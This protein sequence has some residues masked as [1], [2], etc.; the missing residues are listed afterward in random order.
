LFCLFLF[1]F[2]VVSDSCFEI[3]VKNQISLL[4]HI[5]H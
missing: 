3:K 4:L 5:S 2:L 1:C